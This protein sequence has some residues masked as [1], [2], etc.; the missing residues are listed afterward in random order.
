MD[1]CAN[2][3][4][5]IGQWYRHLDKG[6]S[7]LV[8][9]YD[10]RTGTTEIQTFDGDLDEVDSE[11]WD[12][13]RVAS[14]EPPE[15]WTGPV[16]NVA[17]DDLGYSE[18][19]MKGTDWEAPLQSLPAAREAWESTADGSDDLLQVQDVPEGDLTADNV[20]ARDLARRTAQRS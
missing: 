3:S 18:T 17:V 7:F 9:G 13:L 5:R 16:D 4:P 19:A 2:P 11:S 12:E 14:I 20:A 8:T 6:E 1:M 15:D 10:E